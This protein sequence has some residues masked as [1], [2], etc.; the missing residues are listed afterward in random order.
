MD[1]YENFL[2]KAKELHG[3]VCAGVVM[4]GQDEPGCHG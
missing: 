2:M 1:Q 4:G 3:G